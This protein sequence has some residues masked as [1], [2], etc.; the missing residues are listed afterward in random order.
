MQTFIKLD[1]I[2]S[3]W[4]EVN[5][6]GMICSADPL[7]GIIDDEILTGKWFVIFNDDRQII[8]GLGSRDEA[9]QAFV[10]ASTLRA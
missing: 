6:R 7:G 3:G 4:N 2:C 10:S 1:D 5:S 9:I 8:T